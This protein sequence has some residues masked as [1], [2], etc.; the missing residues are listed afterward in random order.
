MLSIVDIKKELGKNIYIYPLTTSAIKSNSIDLH[1]S[2]FAWSVSTKKSLVDNNNRIIIPPHDTALIY[3]KESIYVSNKIGG[4]YHSK[5]RLASEGLGHIGTSLDAQYI[6]L[7]IVAIHNIT[8]FAKEIRVGSEFVTIVFYYLHTAD[9]SDTVSN[10]NPPGHPDLLA[11]LEKKK[12]FLEWQEKNRWCRNKSDLYEAMKKSDEYRECKECLNTEQ[13]VFN[14]KFFRKKA[15]K[16]VLIFG[17]SFLITALIS[18]PAYFVQ[19]EN[20]TEI[21]AVIIKNFLLPIIAAIIAANINLDLQEE[22][23]SK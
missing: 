1:A 17:M 3:S 10:E 23:L 16:Y 12:D 8:D 19:I 14:R 13:V 11:G 18:I 9:F 20:L 5:V 4:T 7:S 6:G 15:V 21:C 2:R 22:R